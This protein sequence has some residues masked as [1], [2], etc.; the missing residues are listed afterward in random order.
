MLLIVV[1]FLCPLNSTAYAYCNTKQNGK[2]D[3]ESIA[4]LS[5]EEVCQAYI[6]EITSKSTIEPLIEH[7]GMNL[8]Y[9]LE[10]VKVLEAKM[11]YGIN[12]VE[13][14]FKT[15][16]QPFVGSHNPV[17]TDEF[18]FRIS[19]SE[20]KLLKYDHVESFPISPHLKQYYKNIKPIY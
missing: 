14:I 18:T 1:S 2:E 11:I 20:I 10:D 17:G 15:Q 19:D 4:P 13:F 8:P 3:P 9:Q 6:A 16:V 7:Y 5:K 12:K